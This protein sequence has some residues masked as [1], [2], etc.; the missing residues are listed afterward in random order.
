MPKSVLF[1]LKVVKLAQ[2]WGLRHQSSYASGGW[3][4]RPQTP[5]LALPHDEFLFTCLIINQRFPLT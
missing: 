3:G 1:F 5:I 2:R 4:R